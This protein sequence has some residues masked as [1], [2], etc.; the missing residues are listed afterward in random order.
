MDR[1]RCAA[2]T[3]RSATSSRRARTSTPSTRVPCARRSRATRCATL[4]PPWC[5]WRRATR[6]R[7]QAL[8]A[9][10]RTLLDF[11]RDRSLE[12]ERLA[13]INRLE[14]ELEAALGGEP[15]GQ[16][17]FV[18][19]AALEREQPWP[20]EAF[21]EIASI[22]RSRVS[23]GLPANARTADAQRHRLARAVLRA[24]L[25]AAP[26][27]ELEA[28]GCRDP[29]RGVATGLARVALARSTRPR[30]SRRG[31]FVDNA[32]A[33]WWPPRRAPRRATCPRPRPRAKSSKAC[34]RPLATR[35][36]RRPRSLAGRRPIPERRGR[37]GSLPPSA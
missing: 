15:T 20:R 27:A 4:L 33:T 36:S 29:A 31:R 21:D 34:A 3:R 2:L 11:A 13:Q 14:F 12:G 8:I 1:I 18:Q 5:C 35:C 28:A 17:V 16:P 19:L 25:G 7:A 26:S 30:A 9:Y 6:L 22:A 24:M 32:F 37:R 23:F 10:A